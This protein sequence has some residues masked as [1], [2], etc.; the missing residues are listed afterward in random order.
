MLGITEQTY[1]RWR[2]EYG[3]LKMNQAKRLKGQEVENT[4]LRLIL[5]LYSSA[6]SSHFPPCCRNAE[7]PTCSESKGHTGTQLELVRV[8][9][10]A[11]DPT[12]KTPEG[13][14]PNPSRI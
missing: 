1:Y 8:V 6:S 10:L 4:R 5:C 13:A 7:F 2:K 9:G 3:G 11:Y 14:A 12:P